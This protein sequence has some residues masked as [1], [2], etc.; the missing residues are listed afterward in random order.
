[1][2]L[3]ELELPGHVALLQDGEHVLCDLLVLVVDLG[4]V[5]GRWRTIGH[6]DAILHA[7]HGTAA[8]ATC[9]ESLA[10]AKRVSALGSEATLAWPT[11]SPP[12]WR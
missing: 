6:D 12:S 8:S 11:H 3:L 2:P 9:Q 5:V 10:L 4:H 1:M 7:V